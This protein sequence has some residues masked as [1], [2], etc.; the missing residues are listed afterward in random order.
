MLYTTKPRKSQ[1][2]CSDFLRKVIRAC[3]RDL[4]SILQFFPPMQAREQFATWSLNFKILKKPGKLFLASNKIQEY[5]YNW[6]NFISCLVVCSQPLGMERKIIA[7]SQITR[8]SV[9]KGRSTHE[10][11][12]ARLN[13]NQC[14]CSATPTQSDQWVKVDLRHPMSI[15]GIA[16]QGDPNHL[17]NFVTKFKLR[18]SVD[19][20][21][22]F[23]KIDDRYFVKVRLQISLLIDRLIYFSNISHILQEQKKRNH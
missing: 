20:S 15:T 8:S 13:N 21:N 5:H 23:Y 2:S 6:T 4:C 19:G 3:K 12:Q 11:Y 18:Y 1:L 16:T 10:G 9:Y 22:Y 7:D 14:W 17:P